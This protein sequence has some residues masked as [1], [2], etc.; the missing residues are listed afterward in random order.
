M[1]PNQAGQTI[2]PPGTRGTG[3]G[4]GISGGTAARN[5]STS[6]TTPATLQDGSTVNTGTLTNFTGSGFTLTDASGRPVSVLL[7]PSTSFVDFSGNAVTS[8]RFSSSFRAGSP[9]PATVYYN[10]GADGNLVATRVVM[11]QPVLTPAQQEAAAIDAAG[12]VTEVSP[13]ILVIE[14]PGASDTPVRYVNNKTTNYVNENGEPVPPESV[15]AGTPVKIFYTKVGDTLV[16]SRVE[17]RSG[18]KAGLPAPPIKTEAT[19]TTRTK[20]EK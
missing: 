4:V 19:T 2:A 15:K 9:T 13:G 12:T 8:S 20:V 17:V 11:S 7:T 16:A 18:D 10:Q 1:N 3:A 5:S 14:Q 6:T